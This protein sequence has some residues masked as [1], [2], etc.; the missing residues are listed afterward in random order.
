MITFTRWDHNGHP[1]SPSSETQ[2]HYDRPISL[3]S[4]LIRLRPAFHGRTPIDAYS[5]SVEPDDHFR[6]WQQDPWESDCQIRPSQPP[7]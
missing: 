1:R 6:N 5:L 3:G 7:I 4:Q 2:Y